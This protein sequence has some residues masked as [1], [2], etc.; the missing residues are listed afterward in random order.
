MR[1]KTSAGRVRFIGIF[2]GLVFVVWLWI[3]TNPIP[4]RDDLLWAT[5]SGHAFGK[6][7]LRSVLAST[8]D[9]L[10]DRNGRIADGAAQLIFSTQ[11]LIGPIMAL[12]LTAFSVSVWALLR[13]LVKI[14][15]RDDQAVPTVVRDLTMLVT[16]AMFVWVSVAHEPDYAESTVFFMSATIGYFGGSALLF[17]FLTLH[18]KLYSARNT[19]GR[20]WNTWAALSVVLAIIGGLWNEIVGLVI[21]G[22]VSATVVFS[23]GRTSRFRW[24]S[25]VVLVL[26][27][28][29]FLTPGLYSRSERVWQPAVFDELSTLER[30][31]MLAIRALVGMTNIQFIAVVMFAIAYSVYMWWESERFAQHTGLSRKILCVQGVTTALTLVVSRT[32]NTNAQIATRADIEVVFCTKRTLVFLVLV[33]ILA[34]LFVTQAVLLWRNHAHGIPAAL[35]ILAPTAFILPM[36]LGTPQGR[37]TYFF[38]FFLLFTTAA[39]AFMYSPAIST[40]N[41]HAQGANYSAAACLLIFAAVVGPS[42]RAGYF[43]VTDYRINKA[44]WATFP[45]QVREYKEGNISTIHL[46]REM[47]I[48]HSNGSYYIGEFADAPELLGQYYDVPASAIVHELQE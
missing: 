11:G 12:I 24:Y 29:R 34:A 10:V 14:R 4:S 3:W 30:Q 44:T 2:W 39:V 45:A 22:F 46:P 36:Y 35:W 48:K 47:P 13:E 28:L 37:Q 43:T 8:W 38:L 27:A 17:A 32:I 9:D 25:V 42:F 33:S 18:T 23:R 26:S 19:S 21:F 16:A 20:R 41:P 6:T 15:A 31:L 40:Q 1:P 5:R 7:S